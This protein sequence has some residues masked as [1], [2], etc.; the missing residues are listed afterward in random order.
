MPYL[1]VRI[2]ETGDRR[3]VAPTAIDPTREAF[4]EALFRFSTSNC[5]FNS[6]NTVPNELMIP[7]IMPLHRKLAKTT[8]QAYMV[9]NGFIK[10]VAKKYFNDKNI[11]HYH[12]TQIT[13]NSNED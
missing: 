8:S 2:A 6:T 11:L 5:S 1:S 9:I 7:N 4:V 13:K 3:K 12:I 10:T